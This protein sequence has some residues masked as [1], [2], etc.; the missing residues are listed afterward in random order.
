MKLFISAIALILF[1]SS[2]MA[3]ERK[4]TEIQKATFKEHLKASFEKLDL[5]EEQKPKFTEFTLKYLLQIKTLK[6]GDQPKTAKVEKF[7]SIIDAKNKEMKTLL[8]ANQYK[9]Y[10]ATQNERLNK[11]KQFEKLD[12]TEEQK[13]KFKEITKKYAHQIRTLKADDVKK[14]L[15]KLKEFKSII[16][17]KNKEMKTLLSSEQFKVYKETQKERLRTMKENRKRNQF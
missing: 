4:L 16:D 9:V 6:A 17:S 12:L 8:S 2:A 14:K 1:A 13:P 15:A 3:Q 11:L 5:T 10:E 7:K